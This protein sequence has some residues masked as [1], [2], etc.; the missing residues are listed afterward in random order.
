V[1]ATAALHIGGRPQVMDEIGRIVRSI[2]RAVSRREAGYYW[3]ARRLLAAQLDK[4][5]DNMADLLWPRSR[6]GRCRTRSSISI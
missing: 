5:A 3:V 6:G 4:V 1:T 2:R